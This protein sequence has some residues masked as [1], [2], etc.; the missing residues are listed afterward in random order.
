MRKTY[1]DAFEKKHGVR[2]GFMSAFVKAASAALTEIPAVNA[3]VDLE[4]KEIVY[5]NYHDISVAVAS[6]K[7]LAAPILRNAEDMSFKDVEMNIAMLAE[8]A[9]NNSLALEDM[10]GGTFTISNGGVF[11]S[12]MGT[13]IMNPPQSAI[14]GMHAT[15]M[16]PM[17]VNGEV[18]PR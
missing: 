11:G 18:V 12:L 3:Y 5:R 2:L 14:L 8:K 10:T 13:P 4:T 16:R 1:K 17:V 9:K 7:G 6:P 15:K